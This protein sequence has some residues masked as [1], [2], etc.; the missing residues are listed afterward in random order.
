MTWVQV[1]FGKIEEVVHKSVVQAFGC[2]C[3]YVYSSIGKCIDTK[4]W[5]KGGKG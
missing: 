2:G 4:C 5:F 3:T 1:K